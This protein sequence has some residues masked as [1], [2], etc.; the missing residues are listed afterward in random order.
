M[1]LPDSKTV[2]VVDDDPE[3]TAVI[4]SALTREGYQCEEAE[5]GAEALERLAER[6]A[7]LVIADVRMP[8]MS[9]FDLL[10][11]IAAHHPTTFVL[12]LTGAADV[13]TVVR[14]LR[15]GACDFITKPLSLGDLLSR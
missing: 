9:G 4:G 1:E 10:D 7:A 12:L 8:G 3:I 6:P 5:S 13:P 15:G 2:L 14:A 11:Q